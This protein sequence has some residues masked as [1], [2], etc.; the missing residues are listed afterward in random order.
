M[1]QYHSPSG[2]VCHL[3]REAQ[4]RLLSALERIH[5]VANLDYFSVTDLATYL[6][7]STSSARNF[8]KENNMVKMFP[9]SSTK[10]STFRVLK[11]DVVNLM[12]H[13][14]EENRNV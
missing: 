6:R 3:D 5:A 11:E 9:V 12:T 4:N 14:Y 13:K 7:M 1:P 10:G 2:E 8:I